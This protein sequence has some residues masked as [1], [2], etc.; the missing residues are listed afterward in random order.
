MAQDFK[1]DLH[2]MADAIFALQEA[3]IHSQHVG[4]W[5]LVLYSLGLDNGSSQR[6]QSSSEAPGKNGGPGSIH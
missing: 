6:Y 2:F 5:Q 1:P 4:G 3:S